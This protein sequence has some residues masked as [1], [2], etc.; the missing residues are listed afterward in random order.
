MSSKSLAISNHVNRDLFLL[1]D[2]V[3]WR[4]CMLMEPSIKACTRYCRI[5]IG[6]LRKVFIFKLTW[7]VIFL[8][9]TS[10]SLIVTNISMYFFYSLS[11]NKSWSCI[12]TYENA[13]A[14][15]RKLRTAKISGRTS[16]LSRRLACTQ[17]KGQPEHARF[18]PECWSRFGKYWVRVQTFGRQYF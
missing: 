8:A 3:S 9:E 7:L 5:G 14:V 11:S 17:K 4:I 18:N 16:R 2:I 10:R 13:C 6:L 12:W 1:L 15:W